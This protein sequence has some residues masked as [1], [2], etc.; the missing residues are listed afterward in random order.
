VPRLRKDEANG[1][2]LKLE[3]YYKRPIPGRLTHHGDIV[4]AGESLRLEVEVAWPRGFPDPAIYDAPPMV[5]GSKFGTV[6]LLACSWTFERIDG[7]AGGPVPKGW[8]RSASTTDA[9]TLQTFQLGPEEAQGTFRVTCAARFDAYFAPAMFTR[10]I[11]VLS[12]RAAM[13]KLQTEAFTGLGASSADRTHGAWH[14]DAEPGFKATPAVGSSANVD[15][16]MARDRAL[17]RE[18]LRAVA[19]YLR[20]QSS[21]HEAVEAIERE[22]AR[23]EASEKLLV[24]DRAKGW[25][26]FQLRGAYLS[27]TEGLA[28]GPLDLHG[29]VHVELAQDP[30]RNSDEMPRVGPTYDKVVVQIRDLSRRFEQNDFVFRGEGRSFESALHDAFDDLAVAY[31]KGLV[32]IEAEE[33]RDTALRRGSGQSGPDASLG[34]ATGK[35]FGFQR[36]TDSTWKSIKQ[37]VWDPVVSFAVNLGAIALMTFVPPS[38][39]IVTPALIAYNSIPAVDRIATEANRGTLTLGTFAMSTGEIALN[40]LPMVARARPFTPGWYAVETAN[41]GGQLALMTAE[42]VQAA[43]GLQATH[44][45]A[46]ADEYQQYLELQKTSLPSDPGLA[47]AKEAIR[48]HAAEVE[49]EISR[50]FI[51]LAKGNLVQMVAGSV[52]HNTSAR[53][54]EA[55]IEHLEGAH[56]N[57]V[58]AQTADPPARADH[59]TD[60]SASAAPTDGSVHVA[61]AARSSSSPH[62]K[63]ALPGT[64]PW[65]VGSVAQEHGALA[66]AHEA[67]SARPPVSD[68]ER[69]SSLAMID[70]GARNKAL[71]EQHAHEQGSVPIGKVLGVLAE[72][73]KLT[74]ESRRQQIEL[75]EELIQQATRK[76]QHT[77]TVTDLSPAATHVEDGVVKAPKK[78]VIA[79]IE[80]DLKTGLLNQMLRSKRELLKLVPGSKEFGLAQEA[81]SKAVAS[82]RNALTMKKPEYARYDA[83]VNTGQEFFVRYG[84]LLEHGL[85]SSEIAQQRASAAQ[86]GMQE[87]RYSPKGKSLAQVRTDAAHLLA[88]RPEDADVSLT[89]A[90]TKGR[91][92]DVEQRLTVAYVKAWYD[93]PKLQRMFNGIDSAGSESATHP[94]A[95]RWEASAQR[96]FRNAIVMREHLATQLRTPSDAQALAHRVARITGETLA[97]AETRIERYRAER[98]EAA[99][100]ATEL[101]AA[102]LRSSG[103]RAVGASPALPALDPKS[104]QLIERFAGL[105]LEEV[106]GDTRLVTEALNAW[107]AETGSKHAEVTLFGDTYHAGEQLLNDK[108]TPFVLL[109]Q[110]DQAVSLGA[111][112]IGHAL[113]LGVSPDVLMRVGRLLPEER[114]TFAARQRQVIEHV[115]ARGVVIEAN[116]SSNQEISN[117]THKEHP[118]GRFVEEGLRVTVNTDDETILGTDIRS[119]LEKVSRA[120]GVRRADLAAMML[121]SY[122]SRLGNRELAHRERIKP[123]LARALQTGLSPTETNALATHL[124]RYFHITPARS[125]SA[126]IQRVLDTALGL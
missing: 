9:E 12:S 98:Y 57:A 4:E 2:K 123:A 24:G 82:Y 73:P 49:G 55:I 126:T 91:T 31:P 113:V 3:N 88:N 81:V 46:L 65:G 19:A 114:A 13:S 110:V 60:A 7:S 5:T 120:P 66:A 125:P 34:T 99:L 121:E 25:Q 83:T 80:G 124:A 14:A 21:G 41:W 17:Q 63:D 22:L 74:H 8:T 27:R 119:E 38:A 39:P 40:I 37:A 23:Q 42:A 71:A 36:S 15:D 67:R 90:P 111:D 52:V 20:D 107:S 56:G 84:M 101:R 108:V 105:S 30:H 1:P 86:L 58:L 50:Q 75:L 94:P 16:P 70:E 104:G 89:Y 87:L 44:V 26:P 69:A 32:S 64:E 61:P 47:N 96:T 100:E 43:R 117:L 102:R 10:D 103:P 54:H 28:S 6:A 77:A 18:R 78:V 35:V 109:D 95:T 97:L 115:R 122:R 29:T 33:I 68:A 93:D 72:R 51:E 11:V 106:A 112:R 79:S 76:G 116:L 59:A 92:S 45:K 62:E 48:E 53:A 118:A 85:S